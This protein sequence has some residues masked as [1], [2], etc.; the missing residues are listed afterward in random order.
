MAAEPH[1]PTQRAK[2]LIQLTER[3]CALIA[4]E[5]CILAQERPSGLAAAAE[6]RAELA[7]LY[8]RHMA[9]LGRDRALL[10]D[11]DAQ[12]LSMLHAATTALR[13]AASEHAQRLAHRRQVTEGL[14]QILAE[15][16]N[17]KLSRP[18][19]YDGQ[20]TWRQAPAAVAALAVNHKV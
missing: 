16:V 6:E 10:S 11:A 1:E 19:G 20:A 2:A 13:N 4:A 9:A 3:L 15:T 8:A 7:A 18:L 14:V 12:A 5:A 17:G